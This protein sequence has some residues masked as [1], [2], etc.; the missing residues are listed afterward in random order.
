MV[1][2]LQD[3]DVIMTKE[4]QVSVTYLFTFDPTEVGISE[5]CTN[6]E[7]ECAING[8]LNRVFEETVNSLG[9]PNDIEIQIE[10]K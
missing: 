9:M 3:M 4:A 8:Y 6:K 7:F 5:G 10:E 2:K 1:L